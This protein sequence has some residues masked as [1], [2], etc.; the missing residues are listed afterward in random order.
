L[1][2]YI[3]DILQ[4]NIKSIN[5]SIDSLKEDKFEIITRRNCLKNVIQNIHIL[6]QHDISVKLNIVCI[7]GFNDDEICDF[8]ALTKQLPLHVRFIEFMPFTGNDWSPDTVVSA[9]T[10]LHLVSE[11]F[12]FVK[13]KDEFNDTA[14]KYKPLHHE[15]T[16]A[17]ISTITNPFCGGCNRL[18]LTADGKMK[19][20]LFSKNETDLLS[21]LR[22][23][24]DF[25]T[26]IIDNLYSK[27]KERGGQFSTSYQDL[28]A[29]HIINRSMVNIGG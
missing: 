10:I 5:V 19:N 13:L 17:I 15:G 16:F 24:D 23:G 11:Q 2:E 1:H 9:E 28:D 12:T 25:T 20:C 4:A 29:L 8:V 26:L 6:L 22:S 21:A 27:A 3:D 14:R 7:K 18:R